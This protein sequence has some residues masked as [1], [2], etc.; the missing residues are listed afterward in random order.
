MVHEEA[1]DRTDASVAKRDEG[2]AH[3]SRFQGHGKR[4]HRPLAG[5]GAKNRIGEHRQVPPGRQQPTTQK[6]RAGAHLHSRRLKPLGSCSPACCCWQ[7]CREYAIDLVNLGAIGGPLGSAL[8]TLGTLTPGVKALVGFISFVVAL[9]SLAALRNFGPVLYYIGVAI[10][11][12][13]GLVI[14]QAIMGAVI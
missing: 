13:V 12:T 3:G 11:A 5:I 9:I 14:A 7:L 6:H 2:H 1:D 4:F 10:F 8:N